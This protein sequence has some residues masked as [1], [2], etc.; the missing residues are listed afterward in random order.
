MDTD[1]TLLSLLPAAPP[2]MSIVDICRQT[3]QRAVDATHALRR[4]QAARRAVPHLE[5]AHGRKPGKSS[6]PKAGWHWRRT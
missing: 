1:E 5:H 6:L 2:G 4:L 3:G